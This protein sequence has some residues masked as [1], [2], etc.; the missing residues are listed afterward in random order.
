MGRTPGPRPERLKCPSRASK[1]A[2]REA[3]SSIGGV[4]LC[5]IPNERLMNCTEQLEERK[6]ALGTFAGPLRAENSVETEREMVKG[7]HEAM[8]KIN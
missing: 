3:T 4:P 5:H 1:Q 2:Q 7:K 8:E 6:G